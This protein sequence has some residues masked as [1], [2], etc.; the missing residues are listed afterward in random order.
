MGM[1]TRKRGTT[2]YT[3]LPSD[4]RKT[5]VHCVRYLTLGHENTKEAYAT[6]TLCY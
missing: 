5:P 3:L 2:S 6:R 4:T 1:N